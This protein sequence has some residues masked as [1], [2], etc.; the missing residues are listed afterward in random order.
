MS[1]E[2]ENTKNQSEEKQEASVAQRIPLP[3]TKAFDIHQKHKQKW[4]SVRERS[5]LSRSGNMRYIAYELLVA[6]KPH[7]SM[8]KEDVSVP[9]ST[10]FVGKLIDYPHKHTRTLTLQLGASFG[11]FQIKVGAPL[12]IRLVVIAAFDGLGDTSFSALVQVVASAMN[13]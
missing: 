8:R 13:D 12:D 2:N 10:P 1:N 4:R 11:K 3:L 7:I 9:Q 5:T 6:T